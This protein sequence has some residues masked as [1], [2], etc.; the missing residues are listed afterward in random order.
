MTLFPKGAQ[1]RVEVVHS[2]SINKGTHGGLHHELC[3]QQCIY[4]F[5]VGG[6][7]EGY[8]FIWKRNGKLLGH[9]GQARIPEIWDILQLLSLAVKAEWL[10]ESQIASFRR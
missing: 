3:F 5:S 7:E 10:D 2:V 4:H 9:R 1:T 8:R 6:P